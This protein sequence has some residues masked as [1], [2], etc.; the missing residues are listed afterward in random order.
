MPVISFDAARTRGLYPTAGTATAHLDGGFSALHP[1]SVI[2]AI[3]SALRSSPSQPG[4]ASDRSKRAAHTV[5]Q[6]RQA[7]ADLVGVKAEDVVLGHS[8]SS[9]MLRFATLLAR[10]WQLGDE[11]VLSRLDSDLMVRAWLRAAR[12]S[13]A[14]T[15]WA[16]VDVETGQLPAWQYAGGLI[17]ERTQVVTIP[18][19]NPATGTVPNVRAVA[20]LAHA[21]GAIVIVDAGSAL[22]HMPIDMD[23]L[24]ADLMTV[25]A[26]TFGGP[27][28]ASMVA[29]PGI[30]DRL[31]EDPRLPIPQRFEFGPLPVELL[32]GLTAAVDHLAGLDEWASG[33]RRERLV[34]SLT[35]AGAYE[36]RLYDVLDDGLRSI[37][38]VTVLG[39]ATERLPTAAFSVAGYEPAHVGEYLQRRGISV[40]TGPSGVTE[41]LTAFGADEFGGA[42]FVGVMP[43][44]AMREVHMFLE[45]LAALAG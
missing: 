3:V 17:N 44:T 2:R 40:W 13:A 19:A 11:V 26:T 10:D 43:H 39:T 5:A 23:A 32:D 8:A 21:Y 27:T 42:A 45:A 15:R 4:S 41:L 33:N 34:A 22:P 1:E 31:D 30:L 35:A 24:G 25:S 6:A 29:A 20:D 14:V 37:R 18:L 36:Q 38:R 12:S 28:V 7:M 16:E 9:L